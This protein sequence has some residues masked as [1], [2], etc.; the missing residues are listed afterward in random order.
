M[1]IRTYLLK[2]LLLSF[3]ASVFAQENMLIPPDKLKDS[4]ILLEQ[5]LSG[6][7]A[8][9]A[10]SI[11]LSNQVEKAIKECNDKIATVTAKCGNDCSKDNVNA[12]KSEIT[13]CMR[14]FLGMSAPINSAEIELLKFNLF[15]KSGLFNNMVEFKTNMLVKLES[16][17]ANY[18]NVRA[19][20]ENMGNEYGKMFKTLIANEFAQARA[21]G[22]LAGKIK[23]TCIHL[24]SAIDGHRLTLDMRKFTKDFVFW[25]QF[26]NTV[27]GYELVSN[28]LRDSCPDE[29]KPADYKPIAD[30]VE[31]FL[32][33]IADDDWI[34]AQCKK[35]KVKTYL[36][37]RCEGTIS[38][39]SY[40]I[41]A[42]SELAK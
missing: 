19:F 28:A 16:I 21:T 2:V 5:G 17:S 25:S 37:K 14:T 15:I 20:T 26:Y 10:S 32:K 35:P 38:V 29:F 3:S 33:T 4:A 31:A 13:G 11:D 39:D 7:K 40:F 22:E 34:R 30:D 1:L 9:L 12:L 18:K 36:G 24:K 42:I 6:Y 41:S 8:V 23:G 27:K